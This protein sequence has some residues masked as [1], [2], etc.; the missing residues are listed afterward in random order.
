MQIKDCYIYLYTRHLRT[1][2]SEVVLVEQGCL[3]RYIIRYAAAVKQEIE[4][5][6]FVRFNFI[7]IC[8]CGVQGNQLRISNIFTLLY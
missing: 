7:S 1:L 5:Y 2:S 8:L 6:W 3:S 4:V